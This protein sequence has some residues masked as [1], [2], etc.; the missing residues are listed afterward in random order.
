MTCNPDWPEIVRATKLCPAGG[1]ETTWRTDLQTR[2]F[3]LKLDA[4]LKDL[5]TDHVFGE[6]VGHIY[7]VEWQKRGLPHAHILLILANND[8]P[9]TPGQIDRIVSAELPPPDLCPVLFALVKKHNIHRCKSECQSGGLARCSANFPFPTSTTTTT[10]DDGY[11][12]YRRTAPAAALSPEEQKKYLHVAH[13]LA[14]EGAFYASNANVISYSPYLTMKYQ[15][16]INVQICTSVRAVKYLFK[17]LF[18]GNDRVTATVHKLGHGRFDEASAYLDTRYMCTS[19]AFWRIFSFSLRGCSHTVQRLIVHLEGQEWIT[20]RRD[21]VGADV[22]NPSSSSLIAWFGLNELVHEKSWAARDKTIPA[23]GPTADALPA[24]SSNEEKK[25]AQQAKRAADAAA[26]KVEAYDFSLEATYADIVQKFILKKTKGSDEAVQWHPLQQKKPRRVGRMYWVDISEGER[27]YLRLLLNRVPGKEARSFKLLR[28]FCSDDQCL[29]LDRD[30]AIAG[31]PTSCDGAIEYATFAAAC[32]ARFPELILHDRIHH[33]T[34]R[35]ADNEGL[36]VPQMRDL[37]VLLLVHGEVCDKIRLWNEHRDRL[38]VK[39]ESDFAVLRALE[40]L[41]LSVDGSC[42]GTHD[43]PTPPPIEDDEFDHDD[44]RQSRRRAPAEIQEQ[45]RTGPQR[46]LLA[47]EVVSNRAMFNDEQRAV[48]DAIIAVLDAMKDGT[49]D[50]GNNYFVLDA[51][52]GCGKT[53]L[54]STLLAYARSKK[55][56]ALA[57]AYSGIA[58]QLLDGG[59]TAH[60]RFMFPK[61]PIEGCSCQYQADV[62]DG[63]DLTFHQRLAQRRA[64]TRVLMEADLIVLDEYTMCAKHY[65]TA[66]DNMLRDLMQNDLPFGGKVRTL[67]ISLLSFVSLCISSPRFI[68]LLIPTSFLRSRLLYLQV[69]FA[70]LCLSSKASLISRFRGW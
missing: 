26:L 25:A 1:D 55:H 61:E 13:G 56:V 43:L 54:L 17:Y 38:R 39:D 2:V 58:A 23:G 7:C 31:Y 34:L 48:F 67:S 65:V 40:V 53:F 41:L 24:N 29:H 15:S 50:G 8:M 14:R 57:T 46:T 18:K 47:A 27:F 6:H 37:F 70:R 28:S 30:L 63:D 68:A 66:I 62:H 51:P 69:T 21:T 42:L 60:Y 3:K 36:T 44:I 52:G 19:E 5:K 4:L 32:L 64:R 59:R 45:Y 33:D 10:A 16:H 49:T 11:P 22:E 12:L 9:M 20:Y 35:D